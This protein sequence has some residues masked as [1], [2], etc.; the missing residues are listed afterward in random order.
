MRYGK[1][2]HPE[3]NIKKKHEKMSFVAVF[4]AE[5]LI[6]RAVKELEQQLDSSHLLTLVAATWPRQTRTDID[7]VH[8]VF[9]CNRKS[10]VHYLLLVEAYPSD[11]T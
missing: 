7:I 3:R 6:S 5:K 10:E 4:Q 8:T 2:R 1:R 11:I 9:T